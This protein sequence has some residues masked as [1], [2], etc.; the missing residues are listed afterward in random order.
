MF[1]REFTE[2]PQKLRREIQTHVE[3][4]QWNKTAVC[5]DCSHKPKNNERRSASPNAKHLQQPTTIT[6][7]VETKTI[8]LAFYVPQ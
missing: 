6:V 4:T 3:K 7:V 2:A 1:Y 8:K 5:A